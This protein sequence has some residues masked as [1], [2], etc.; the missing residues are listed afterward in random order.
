MNVPSPWVALLLAAASYRIWRLLAED[1]ILSGPR[2]RIVRLPQNWNEGMMLPEG[3]RYRLAEFINCA[4]CS[5][6]WISIAVWLLWQADEHWATVIAVPLA[7]S[8]AV[9]VTRNLLDPVE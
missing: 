6:F 8:A 1:T 2:R 4:W 9:G 3:Y 7:I 5:G